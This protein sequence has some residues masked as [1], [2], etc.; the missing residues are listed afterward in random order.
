[1]T[2]RTNYMLY[3]EEAIA[4]LARKLNEQRI[5]LEEAATGDRKDIALG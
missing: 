2:N 1:M 4:S 5:K 3:C